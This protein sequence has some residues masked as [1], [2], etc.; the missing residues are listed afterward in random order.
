MLVLDL[1]DANHRDLAWRLYLVRKIVN[2]E[3]DWKK[4][5]ADFTKGFESY[6]PSAKLIEEKKKERANEKPKPE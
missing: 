6:A 3:K 1:I 4:A 5:D 2:V